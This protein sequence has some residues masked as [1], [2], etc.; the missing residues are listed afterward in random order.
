MR[1]VIVDKILKVK[2][3]M[4][5]NVDLERFHGALGVWLLCLGCCPYC[6]SGLLAAGRQRPP[7]THLITNC[8]IFLLASLQS[9]QPETKHHCCPPQLLT[10]VINTCDILPGLAK[11]WTSKC[12][13]KMII[14]ACGRTRVCGGGMQNYIGIIWECEVCCINL[15]R[16]VMYF[17]MDSVYYKVWPFR[18]SYL[19]AYYV[20]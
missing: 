20:L 10:L 11:S 17:A 6:K 18:L 3:A 19:A 16:D 9:A 8:F 1:L 7:L 12:I 2:V 13:C 4:G 15:W 5:W 14:L